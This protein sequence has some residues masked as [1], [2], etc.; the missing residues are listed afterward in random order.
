MI[1]VALVPIQRTFGIGVVAL[2]WLV[3]SY[4]VVTAV[5][6]SVGGRLADQLGPRRLLCLGFGIV[7][8][9]GLLGPAAPSFGWLLAARLLV[10]LG[11]AATIPTGLS[12]L[13]AAS[14]GRPPAPEA[15]ARVTGGMLAA[16]AVG[17]MLAGGLVAIAGWEAIFL[18]NVAI[19]A[20]GVP[21]AL[22]WL[23]RDP[24]HARGVDL[25]TARRLVD[26][27]GI[28]A[29]TVMLASLLALLLSL[30]HRPL[31]GLAPIAPLAGAV[32]WRHSLRRAEPFLE[33]RAL[34]ANRALLAVCG[35]FLL[36]NVV[37][38]GVLFSISLWLGVVGGYGALAIGLLVAPLGTIGI[39]VTPLAARVVARAGWRPA[40]AVGALGMLTGTLLMLTLGAGT[41]VLG[42][43]GVLAVLGI[44]VGFNNLA[45]QSALYAATAAERTGAAAGLQQTSRYVGAVLATSAFGVVFAHGVTSA[46]L[47]DVALGL[48][49]VSV[50]ALTIALRRPRR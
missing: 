31:W 36:V 18:V 4:Y 26:V 33:L 43:L 44:P 45:L 29:F 11:T 42:I 6:Q 14:H 37:A 50:V 5:G 41:S 15:I 48:A 27:P 46:R 19:A 32:L 17:P 13:R 22:R 23:P 34:A 35:M 1:A 10:A 38:Y 20:A 8:L 30:D 47:H 28:A 49:A 40:F 3:T 21:L 25:A 2:S 9:G 12:L 16:A 24:Q 7:A 39:V